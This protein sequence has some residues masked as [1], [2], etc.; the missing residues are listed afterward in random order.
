MIDAN[1][2]KELSIL[3]T[4]HDRYET[5][6]TRMDNDFKRFRGDEFSIDA[7]E[8]KWECVTSNRPQAEA[9]KLINTLT[10]AERKLYIKLTNKETKEKKDQIAKT[11]NIVNGFLYSYELESSG[12]TDQPTLQALMAF[13]RVV[14]GWGSYR[15]L[16]LEND[17]GK[18]YLDLAIWD[19]R[20][21]DWITGKNGLIKVSYN[22]YIT[23]E[24]AE[25]EFDGFN[26]QTD[27][28]NLVCVYD[29]W[30][31][32]NEKDKRVVKNAVIAGNEYVK[33]PEIV[34]VGG[35]P[36]DRLPVR[37]K[38]GGTTPMIFDAN[39]DN[40]KHVG[41]SWIAN[42]RNLI[43][44]ENRIL[45]YKLTRAG[46]EAKMPQVVY[47]DS[48]KGDGTQPPEFKADPFIKGSVIPLDRGKGQEIAQGLPIQPGVIIERALD[49]ISSMLDQ[50]GLNKIAFGEAEGQMTALGVDL[51][52]KN[53]NQHIL[54]FIE[55]LQGDFV[56]MAHEICK[57]FK[58]GSFDSAEFSGIN[59]K[60]E[61]FD[62]DGSPDDIIENKQFMCDLVVDE[63]RDRAT[64][65]GM[66]IQEVNAKILSRREAIELHQLSPDPDRTLELID[67]EI[68]ESSMDTPIVSGILAQIKD[69]AK[70]PKKEDEFKLNVAIKKLMMI[71][72]QYEPQQPPQT[73]GS[74]TS[75]LAANRPRA[76]LASSRV[77][78]PNMPSNVGGR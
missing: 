20:N 64:H 40:I 56:W 63:L 18:P 22:R 42:N 65:S 62:I 59:S 75:T 1:A 39:S 70:S 44:T 21:V 4:A 35:V 31:L 77:A 30:D 9:W 78:Q 32:T 11:E 41:E 47:W 10:T 49:D 34:K 17:D 58:M 24:S 69:Y 15:L 50:G 45:S 46:M 43:D 73:P 3:K 23:K 5:L 16:I 72:Q 13:Y 71:L 14:R 29:I 55:G 68:Y 8:G 33:N 2:S 36:L 66:A 52:N 6:Y 12:F 67:Q 38:A 37:I 76:N 27:E 26:G 7:S 53:T 51:L 25:D 74:N 60:K 19:T 57:Q 61:T 28:N 54:P 48:S